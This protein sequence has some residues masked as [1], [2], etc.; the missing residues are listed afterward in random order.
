MAPSPVLLPVN[1]PFIFD[2]TIYHGQSYEC[3]IKITDDASLPININGWQFRAAI[4]RLNGLDEPLLVAATQRFND[5]SLVIFSFTRS[6]ILTLNT[7]RQYLFDFVTTDQNLNSKVRLRGAW[8]VLTG[9]S[10]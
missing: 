4:S 3:A 8:S 6:Q 2:R 7:T 1:Q 9:A 10:Y 5:Q